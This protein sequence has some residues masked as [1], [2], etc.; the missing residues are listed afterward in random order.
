MLIIELKLLTWVKIINFELK[1]LGVF[2][3]NY[4]IFIIE[5]K[6]LT[7]VKIINFELKLLGVFLKN[8]IIFPEILMSTKYKNIHS[9]TYFIRF[10]EI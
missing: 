5:L 4:I 6:L 3:K 2:L 9:Q 1:L 8:Y 10:L 7:W